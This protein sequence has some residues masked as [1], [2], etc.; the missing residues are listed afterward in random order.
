ML[1]SFVAS[2]FKSPSEPPSTA[3]ELGSS[4]RALSE[5]EARVAQ[6][7]SLA[8]NGGNPNGAARQG[9]LLFGYLFLGKQEKVT[10]WRSATANFKLTSAQYRTSPACTVFLLAC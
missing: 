6:P 1:R 8:R 9:A 7:P 10:S 2:V 4:R 3:A 5:R